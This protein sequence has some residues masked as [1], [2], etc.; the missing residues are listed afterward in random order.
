MNYHH[1]KKYVA[2]LQVM[3]PGQWVKNVF[4]WAPLI[5]SGEFREAA[6]CFKTGLAF[7]SF[8]L[9]ASAIYIINDICDRVEDQ[10]HPTKRNRPVARGEVGVNT[11]II[12][13]LV[14]LVLSTVL[15]GRVNRG[16]ALMVLLYAGTTIAYSLF[17]KRIAILDVMTIAGGFVLRILGGSVA[18][19]VTPSHWLVLCTIMISLFLGFTKRRAELMALEDHTELARQVLRDYS[20][21]F[22]D[23]AISMVTAATIVC[24][25]LYTVDKRTVEVF[26]T[27]AMLLTVPSVMYGLFRYIYIIYHLKKGED[28]TSTLIRDIPTII[29]LIIW[30]V[31]ALLIVS[32]GGRFDFFPAA[33]V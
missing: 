26:H 15:A 12:L 6:M 27:H 33:A 28:P 19:G 20:A 4:V 31:L 3:R 13:A 17:L 24:Y 23:Q 2:L 8:C 1:S 5:F 22:L 14:L 21:A 25:A 29:N 30:I 9:A 7:V 10:Q 11:A 18:I 32:Y 16:V